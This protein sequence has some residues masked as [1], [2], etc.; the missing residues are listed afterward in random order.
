LALLPLA[1][2]GLE[3]SEKALGPEDPEVATRANNLAVVY[4][5]QRRHAEA[6]LL[7]CR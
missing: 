2:H 6:E 3:I 5:Y 4:R 1:K 7:L